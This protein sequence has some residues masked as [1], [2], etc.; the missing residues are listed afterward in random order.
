LEFIGSP[1]N[2]VN[3]LGTGVFEFFHEPAQGIIKSPKD[4]GTGI[5]KGTRSLVT[6]TVKGIFGTV[7]SITGTIGSGLAELSMDPEYIKERQQ[8]MRE[9]PKHAA[10]GALMGAKELGKGIFKG[11]TGVIEEPIKGAKSEGVG[12]FFKGI[13]RGVIGAAVKPAVGVVD[14]AAQTTQGVSRTATMFQAQHNRRRP[15]RAFGEDGVLEPFSAEKAEGNELMRDLDDEKYEGE[16]YLHH[17]YLPSPS[18]KH[19]QS[20]LLV[21]NDRIIYK[22][23]KTKTSWSEKLRDVE[24][25]D[26]TEESILLRLKGDRYASIPCPDESE[27]KTIVETL[28]TVLGQQI[29]ASSA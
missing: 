15:A 27:R 10:E 21:T 13:G 25:L 2:L 3:N 4:F 19:E 26:L 9:K 14:F 5:A 6:N 8:T 18:S 7:H 20:I 12:G 16:L 11:I 1:V 29:A 24:K 17:F 22:I 23:S 28:Q